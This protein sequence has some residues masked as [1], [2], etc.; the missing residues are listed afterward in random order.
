M[1]NQKGFTLAE[2]VVGIALLGIMGMVAASF[3]VF[4]AKTKNEIVNDI[5]D[6]VDS[7]LAERMLLKDLKNSEPSFNNLLLVDD[8][9]N[10]F[11]DYVSDRT[12]QS[13]DN[14]PRT[15]TLAPGGKNEFIF[16]STSDKLGPAIMYTPAMAYDVGAPSPNPM[17]ASPLNFRSLNKGGALNVSDPDDPSKKL[18]TPGRVLMLDSPAQVREM[19][20]TGPNYNRPARS[21]I[22][23]GT[24]V[25]EGET[26]LN[27]V[28]LGNMLD[29]TNP[30]YPNET[31]TDEDKFLRDLPP[32]G[33]AAPIVRLKPIVIIKYYLSKDNTGKKINLMRSTFDGQRFGDGQLFASDIEKVVFSRKDAHDSLIYYMIA[34]KSTK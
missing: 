17:I 1:R 23:I 28:D 9:G 7:I 11:F 8:N 16:I 22:F 25:S 3:F 2:M 10:R 27:P 6:S 12:D 5:E 31:I 15:L 34:R 20:A 14:S 21:P 30:M 24:V 32:M 19:T 13:V 4:T 18:W 29:R 26:R 33:G